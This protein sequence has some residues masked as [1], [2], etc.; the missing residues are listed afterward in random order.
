MTTLLDDNALM[1]RE[2]DLERLRNAYALLGEDKAQAITALTEL[3]E[4]G[5][6]VSMLYLAQYYLRQ[7]NPDYANAE[8]WN[9]AAYEKG[10]SSTAL[11]NL[12][13]MYYSLRKLDLAEEIF[14]DGAT[15]GNASCM[16]WLAT[17][18]FLYK[19]LEKK[20]E[21]KSLLEC[22]IKR[23]HVRSKHGLGRLL[24]KG[25]YGITNIPR[26]IYLYF[27]GMCESVRLADND[28]SDPR[29]W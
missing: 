17:L 14:F 25:H 10:H 28:P 23:G 24:M 12:G 15:K 20:Q 18:Y 21:I 5:S 9:R 6:I 1:A 3:A 19:Y 26:G 11:F 27:S 22:A 2:R 7:P 13:T 16:Y 29:L 4:H 8:K